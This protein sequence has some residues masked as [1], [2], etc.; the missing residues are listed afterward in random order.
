MPVGTVPLSDGAA[1]QQGR[2]ANGP[3]SQ[4]RLP[5]IETVGPGAGACAFAP[6]REGCSLPVDLDVLFGAAMGDGDHDADADQNRDS[7]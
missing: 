2:T 3:V 7:D 1:G 5:R 6:A 4:P